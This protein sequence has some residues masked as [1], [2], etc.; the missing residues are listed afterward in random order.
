M[1]SPYSVEGLADSMVIRP[2]WAAEESASATT[3]H[4]HLPSVLVTAKRLT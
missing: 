2:H 1:S 3:G 4:P